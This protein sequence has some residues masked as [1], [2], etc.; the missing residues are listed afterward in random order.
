MER[1]AKLKKYKFQ[2]IQLNWREN[3]NLMVIL[4][5]TNIPTTIKSTKKNN[6]PYKKLIEQNI[7]YA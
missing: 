6:T 1:I 7:F 3:V 5:K 4:I 2:G